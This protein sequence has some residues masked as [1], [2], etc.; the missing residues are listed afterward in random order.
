MAVLAS[1]DWLSIDTHWSL[2]WD[3]HHPQFVSQA[4]DVFTAL[5]HSHKFRAMMKIQLKSASC[6]TNKPGHSS[7]ILEILFLIALKL[8]LMH[9]Q[10]PLLPS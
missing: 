5:L 8:C 10:H 2:N 7:N 3:A 6:S 9:D 4:S 1:T